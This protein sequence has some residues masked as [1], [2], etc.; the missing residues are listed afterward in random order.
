[1]SFLGN[2][3]LNSNW[4]RAIKNAIKQAETHLDKVLELQPD[5]TQPS[6]S[7]S[8]QNPSISRTRS[9]RIA[10]KQTTRINSQIQK[11]H[12]NNRKAI[13][14]VKNHNS[15]TSTHHSQPPK[16]KNT[17]STSVENQNILNPS[18]NQ[19]PLIRSE[20]PLPTAEDTQ[21]SFINNAPIGPKSKK[22][23][24]SNASSSQASVVSLESLTKSPISKS[25]SSQTPLS[26][27]SKSQ[28]KKAA[29]SDLYATFGINPRQGAA[30]T[31]E[32]LSNTPPSNISA[33]NP[34]L[35]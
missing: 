7:T 12:N 13:T 4:S 6:A 18:L 30:S 24:S 31:F 25:A 11:D 23:T 27:A 14:S 35:S 28:V 21:T 10:P 34:N 5:T 16:T 22:E 32:N 9:E 17:T 29:L 19:K 26:S 3:E 15:A 20:S 2:I 33:V 1:M 8:S